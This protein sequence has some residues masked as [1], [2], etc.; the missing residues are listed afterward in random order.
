MASFSRSSTITC[1]SSAPTC[2]AYSSR[3]TILQDEQ[4]AIKVGTE[5]GKERVEF[6]GG[7]D[8]QDP[9][10]KY[11]PSVAPLPFLPKPNTDP[12]LVTWDGPEDPEN[13]QNWSIWYRWSITI[14]CTVMTLNVYVSFC[15]EAAL[16]DIVSDS[17]FASSAPSSSVP[18]IA[19][20]FHVPREVG[21]LVTTL[22]LVGFM[23]GPIFWGP[24]SELI[25]RRPIFVGTLAMY[26]IFHV[27]QACAKNMTTLLVTRFICGFF[28]VAPLTNS[29]GVIADMWDPMNR[30]IAT[31]VFAS[32]V[33]LGPVLG[34]IVG[35]L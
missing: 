29:S 14:A 1:A 8:P 27:G 20:E 9:P 28:A 21:N 33:F 30:G 4:L 6:Y 31:S 2:P 13:P 34:P 15:H 17:T 35:S 23:I 11:N 5:L 10:P 26:T 7:N 32:A 12:N 19:H 22:F 16:T 3:T 18:I 24:G 25:G